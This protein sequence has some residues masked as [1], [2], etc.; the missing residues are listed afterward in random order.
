MA[1]FIERIRWG[2]C[3]G[4]RSWFQAR[5]EYEDQGSSRRWR[6]S[7]RRGPRRAVTHSCRTPFTID[8]PPTVG[9]TSA[10]TSSLAFR[11]LLRRVGGEP[12][13]LWR[14]AA[15]VVLDESTPETEPPTLSFHFHASSSLTSQGD[16]RSSSGRSSRRFTLLILR[17]RSIFTMWRKF[18][19][20]ITRMSLTVAMAIC[21]ASSS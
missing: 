13:L 3:Y 17:L 2:A 15:G 5:D 10:H 8:P 19:E 18:Q 11:P 9:P 6:C 4:P 21:R 16:T 1:S 20:T 14:P 12:S 7:V